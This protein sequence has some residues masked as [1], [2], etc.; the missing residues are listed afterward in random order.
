VI[1]RENLPIEL[2]R[3]LGAVP[4]YTTEGQ[5]LTDQILDAS[6]QLCGGIALTFHSFKGLNTFAERYQRVKSRFHRQLNVHLIAD[7]DVATNLDALISLKPQLG[8]MNLVL[9]AYYPNV[10]RSTLVNLMPKQVY[11]TDLPD[12]IKRAM[13]AGFRIAFSEGLIPYFLSRPEIGV[14]TDLLIPTEGHF[15]CYIDI[16]GRM[17]HSSFAPPNNN[18]PSVFQAPTQK[19]WKHLTWWGNTPDYGNCDSCK[20]LTRCSVP[21]LHHYLICKYAPHNDPNSQPQRPQTPFLDWLD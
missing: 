12:A 10:G 20:L 9:L 14:N 6:Q 8:V 17:S 16:E 2:T 7:K 5:N 21:N 15:S 1:G 11:M 13:D 19:I 4:N 3:E 18:T